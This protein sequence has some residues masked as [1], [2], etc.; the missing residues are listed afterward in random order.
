MID[1]IGDKEM[2][3]NRV[4]KDGSENREQAVLEIQEGLGGGEAGSLDKGKSVLY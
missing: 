4:E 2:L 3:G 1:V